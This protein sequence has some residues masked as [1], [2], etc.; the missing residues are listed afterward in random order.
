MNKDTV[1]DV[2]VMKQEFRIHC[3]GEEREDLLL[4]I[5]CLNKKMEEIKS[6]GKI[7]GTEQIA[8]AAAISITREL[9]SIRSQGGFDMNE[10]KRRIELLESK[11]SDALAGIRTILKNKIE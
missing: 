3:S 10:F 7:A 5:S 6:A 11:V 1:L 9:L 4:A 2:T 8:I